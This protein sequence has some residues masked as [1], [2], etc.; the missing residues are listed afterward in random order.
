[1]T[2]RKI[3]SSKFLPS[4][5]QPE[6]THNSCLVVIWSEIGAQKS[7][8]P[9]RQR[10]VSQVDRCNDK[11]TNWAM[12][13]FLIHPI[14]RI[15]PFF[16]FS[17][18]KTWFGG[19]KFSSNEEVIVAVNEYFADFETVYFKWPNVNYASFLAEI[20]PEGIRRVDL[21]RCRVI[22]WILAPFHGNLPNLSNDPRIILVILK[23]YILLG[24]ISTRILGN[25]WTYIQYHFIIFWPWFIYFILI[26][27]VFCD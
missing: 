19:K 21:S 25:Q 17:N 10:A 14:L 6:R 5:F 7:A 13:W 3:H 18:L 16:L 15:W 26:N 20:W 9:S 23:Y 4:K 27:F 12:N 1:M 11:T 22:K 24:I 8:L 2:S